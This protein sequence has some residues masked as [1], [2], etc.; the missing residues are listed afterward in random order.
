MWES[1]CCKTESA[2]SHACRRRDTNASS[3]T[4]IAPTLLCCVAYHLD[5]PHQHN[6][7]CLFFLVPK[8]LYSASRLSTPWLTT[9]ITIVV[10]RTKRMKKTLTKLYYTLILHHV[11]RHKLI[12]DR[13]TK[14][15]KMLFFLLSMSARPC[16]P[17]LPNKTRK[18]LI[19]IL[20]LLLP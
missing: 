15:S 3:I 8:P 12:F 18:K 16:S 20:P 4:P 2:M 14:Q 6:F 11:N 1:A 13:A 10:R 9:Q 17:N 7:H 5:F 19:V